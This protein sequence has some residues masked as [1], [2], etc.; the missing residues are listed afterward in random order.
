[1]PQPI[2]QFFSNPARDV[3]TSNQIWLRTVSDIIA[4]DQ[5]YDNASCHL[6]FIASIIRKVL[7]YSY[8]NYFIWTY[9]TFYLKECQGVPFFLQMHFLFSN[10]HKCNEIR[11]TWG[12]CFNCGLCFW[13]SRSRCCISEQWFVT[14]STRVQVNTVYLHHCMWTFLL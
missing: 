1:M 3:M 5:L 13:I 14:A 2:N 10:N 9:G 8:H 4:W 11:S 12:G 6:L 7:L